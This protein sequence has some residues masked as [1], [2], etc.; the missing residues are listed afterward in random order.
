MVAV[1]LVANSRSFEQ[2]ANSFFRSQW[3]VL[4]KPSSAFAK[5]RRTRRQSSFF[6][7]HCPQ[8]CQITASILHNDHH[9]RYEGG[10]KNKTKNNGR[11]GSHKGLLGKVWTFTSLSKDVADPAG[12]AEPAEINFHI[13]SIHLCGGRQ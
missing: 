4:A 12:A 5:G 11:Q 1:L 3:Q 8:L 13:Y 7:C 9:A 10:E 2:F 6:I